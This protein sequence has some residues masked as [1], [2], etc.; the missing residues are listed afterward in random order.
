MYWPSGSKGQE[1]MLLG[2]LN[3]QFCAQQGKRTSDMWLK[4]D[5][6]KA[7]FEAKM[8]DAERMGID[9]SCVKLPDVKPVSTYHSTLLAMSDV[10]EQAGGYKP[11]D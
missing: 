1:I 5:T 10:I 8:A 9:S 3:K 11:I 4:K 6:A 7:L 2:E